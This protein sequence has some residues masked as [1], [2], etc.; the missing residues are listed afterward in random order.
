[1]AAAAVDTFIG[2]YAGAATGETNPFAAVADLTSSYVLLAPL[3]VGVLADAVGMRWAF[4]VVLPLALTAA[5]TTV[6]AR[7]TAATATGIAAVP[8]NT[9]LGQ[10]AS[11][12]IP[13]G[14]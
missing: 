7:R 5:V 12:G 10:D 8:S 4:G 3:L 1:M 13:A 2:G 14:R 6:I 9:P 11:H